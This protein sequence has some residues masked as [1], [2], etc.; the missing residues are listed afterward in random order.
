MAEPVITK[1]DGSNPF[2]PSQIQAPYRSYT[3]VTRYVWKQGVTLLPVAKADAS[4]DPLP[5]S[6]CQLASPYGYKLITWQ[7]ERVSEAAAREFIPLAIFDQVATVGEDHEPL[8]AENSWSDWHAFHVI[9][10]SGLAPGNFTAANI[11]FEVDCRL[12]NLLWMYIFFHQLGTEQASA[13]AEALIEEESD[14][15]WTKF[16]ALRQLRMRP[17]WSRLD[18]A[19]VEELWAANERYHEENR[20]RHPDHRQDDAEQELME[21]AA[22]A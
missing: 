4:G 9:Y 16:L 20:T 21:A 17:D 6:I 5:A 8:T 11:R 10:E 15:P 18:D 1:R 7:C 3:M 14:T 12:S 2:S 13:K 22:P 19:T